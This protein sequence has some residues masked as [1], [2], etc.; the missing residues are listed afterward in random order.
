MEVSGLLHAPAT[1]TPGKW[2][3]VGP[4]VDPDTG[5][6]RNPLPSSGIKTEIPGGKTCSLVTVLTE[7][8]KFPAG[9][10]HARKLEY[11]IMNNFNESRSS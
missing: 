9:L 2:A 8:P 4:R 7:L 1:L 11:Y 5:E 3:W 10:Q 6:E